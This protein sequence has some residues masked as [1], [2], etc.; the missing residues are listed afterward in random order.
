MSVST[1]LSPVP[2]LRYDNLSPQNE[3][4]ED[5]P[6]SLDGT[7][8]TTEVRVPPGVGV[9]PVGSAHCL[10]RGSPSTVDTY[11]SS[12]YPPSHDSGTRLGLRAHAPVY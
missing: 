4:P 6:V 12:P 3:A 2:V 8:V 1:V 9:P 10:Y 5:L 11:E 7:S